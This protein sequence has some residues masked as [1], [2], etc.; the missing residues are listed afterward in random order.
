MAHN[1]SPDRRPLLYGFAALLILVAAGFLFW[2]RG[3]RDDS[4]GLVLTPNASQEQL[5]SDMDT[6]NQEEPAADGDA[7]ASSQDEEP[8][9]IET[10]PIQETQYD[11]M[12]ANRPSSATTSSAS[13]QPVEPS[14]SSSST[15][16]SSTGNTS[17]LGGASAPR[18]TDLDQPGPSGR[19]LLYLGS[20]ST[21]E[22]AQRRAKELQGKGVPAEVTR[23]NKPDGS[24]VYRV[25]VGFFEG[26][27]RAKAYGEQLKSQYQVDYWI[28]ER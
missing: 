17:S 19:Y 16:K 6:P 24:L 20:F 27:S 4:P 1:D 3:G 21:A 12:D 10:Q 18:S 9:R 8:A 25:R 5:A 15:T 26:H 13:S 23:T 22:N 7:V 28:A 11:A 2:P 14:S